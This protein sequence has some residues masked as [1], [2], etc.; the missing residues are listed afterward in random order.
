MF[1]L[2]KIMSL[3]GLDSVRLKTNVLMSSLALS[4]RVKIWLENEVLNKGKP[5]SKS[6]P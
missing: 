5:V 2:E 4:E 1:L 3:S 6:L